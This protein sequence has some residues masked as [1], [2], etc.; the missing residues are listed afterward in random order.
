MVRQ[1]MDLFP[2]C[3]KPKIII[4]VFAVSPLGT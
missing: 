4:F 2:G 3:D 1:T